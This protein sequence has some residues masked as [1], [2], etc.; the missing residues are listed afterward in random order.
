MQ[1][2]YTSPG[3]GAGSMRLRQLRAGMQQQYSCAQ[4]DLGL[5]IGFGWGSA[6]ANSASLAA[7]ADAY[8]HRRSSSS[9][10]GG[11]SSTGSFTIKHE[12]AAAF[13]AAAAAEALRPC[14]VLPEL[15]E[16]AA[17]FTASSSRGGVFGP[18]AASS[19]SSSSS[20]GYGSGDVDEADSFT[21]QEFLATVAAI[22]Y[23]SVHRQQQQALSRQHSSLQGD[24]SRGAG[25]LSG[26]A[27]ASLGPIAEG[28]EGADAIAIDQHPAPTGAPKSPRRAAP[29]QQERTSF[30]HSRISLSSPGRQDGQQLTAR[31]LTTEAPAAASG[32]AHSHPQQQQPRLASAAR[33]RSPVLQQLALADIDKDLASLGFQPTGAEPGTPTVGFSSSQGGSKS[34]KAPAGSSAAVA[35][36]MWAA[37]EGDTQEYARRHGAADSP[38]AASSAGVVSSPAAAAAAAALSEQPVPVPP[39]GKPAKDPARRVTLFTESMRERGECPAPPRSPRFAD[40]H[41]DSRGQRRPAGVLL[42]GS[43]L[44]EILDSAAAAAASSPTTGGTAGGLCAG[45]A[46]GL[47]LLAFAAA[48]GV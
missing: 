31:Q 32:A 40:R 14:H 48:A 26:K 23:P 25:G 30:D 45:A 19:I 22:N 28:L 38:A 24:G 42:S 18:G 47:Q 5:P 8:T 36:D 41:T 13:A 20:G 46:V 33:S 12:A 15:L 16:D 29:A 21:W 3:F 6:S 9:S 39:E 35:D 44:D 10:S 27:S 4:Q 17:E 2:Y 43:K 34:A 7:A 1:D 11:G 37:L